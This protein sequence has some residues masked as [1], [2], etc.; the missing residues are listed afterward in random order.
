MVATSSG[1]G[2]ISCLDL[3]GKPRVRNGVHPN[4]IIVAVRLDFGDDDRRNSFQESTSKGNGYRSGGRVESE[5]I[6][7]RAR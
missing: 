5:G 6:G 4:V 3:K 7:Y 1:I 2:R